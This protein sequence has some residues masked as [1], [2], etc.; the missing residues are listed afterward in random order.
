MRD[1]LRADL[2]VHGDMHVCPFENWTVAPTGLVLIDTSCSVPRMMVA[3]PATIVA[4]KQ[5]SRTLFT[6]IEFPRRVYFRI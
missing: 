4:A 2:I 3:Q 1:W 6:Y 5:L